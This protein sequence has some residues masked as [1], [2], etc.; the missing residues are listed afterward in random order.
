MP[1]HLLHGAKI[2][3]A[4][5]QV[6]RKGMA[7][8]VRGH[9]LPDARRANVTADD[10]PRAGSRQR[11]AAEIEEQAALRFRSSERDPLSFQVRLGGGDRA[12]AD[13]DDARP[14]TLGPTGMGACAPSRRRTLRETGTSRT[15]RSRHAHSSS[16]IAMSSEIRTPVEEFQH[17]PVPQRK[18]PT[19][20]YGF[21]DPVH[22][23][24]RENGGEPPSEL[25]GVE[26][27]GGIRFEIVL[28]HAP[29]E[30]SAQKQAE[31]R[32]KP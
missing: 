18:T 21:D 14:V 25:R 28:R 31:R 22:L 27:F 10:L 5:E 29:A 19:G 15:T 11:P 3:A 1:Q 16:W 7:E 9:L 24:E 2:C 6:G 4:I 23:L 20:R 8:R 12:F 32:S 17:R 13:R 26:R 30:P